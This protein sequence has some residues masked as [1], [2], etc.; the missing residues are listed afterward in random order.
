M[1]TLLLAR[2]AKSDWGMAGLRDHDRP[3]N[4]RGGRDAPAMAQRL[5]DEGV[6]LQRIVSSTAIRA[7][8]TAEEYAAAFELAVAEEPALYAASAR[9]ILGIA[10]A[11]P[12]DVEVAMLVGHN[13]GMA[14]AVAE[15]TGSF[16][17][18]PT[19][20]VAECAVDVDSWSE[21]IEGSGTLRR[22]RTPRA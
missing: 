10:G 9:T 5:R 15:L 18:F 4:A 3:L 11:L 22:L 13:P 8:R 16:V 1:K 20:A 2:H 7:R 6:G 21:L 12:D 14:D 19:C 17:E